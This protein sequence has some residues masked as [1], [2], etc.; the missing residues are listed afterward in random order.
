MNS[1]TS[2]SSAATASA[3]AGHSWRSPPSSSGSAPAPWPC[4]RPPSRRRFGGGLARGHRRD[5][6]ARLPTHAGRCNAWSAPTAR[7]SKRPSSAS[8][9]PPTSAV[10]RPVGASALA[11][12]GNR[13]RRQRA[14]W[15]FCDRRR[16]QRRGRCDRQ[17][18]PRQSRFGSL[19]DLAWWRRRSA[20]PPRRRRL[21]GPA[22]RA[23]GRCGRRSS[24]LPPRRCR[25][26]T[27]SSY[28]PRRCRGWSKRCSRVATSP[29]RGSA[30]APSRCHCRPT[31]VPAPDSSFPRWGRAAR[32]SARAC[33][34]ATSW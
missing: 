5:G 12:R 27:A 19:A 15:P 6:S 8:I 22:R 17:R 26:T 33:S 2:E 7:A 31:A 13:R 10:F 9:R 14:R 34:S 21:R 11:G 28:R 3:L 1:H 4:A 29:G 16:A 25:A 18:R 24:A 20:D 30:S 32:P 23:R